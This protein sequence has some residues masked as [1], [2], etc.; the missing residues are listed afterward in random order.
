MTVSSRVVRELG[1]TCRPGWS[2]MAT[3]WP[4]A[5]ILKTI[6]RMNMRLEIGG[7]ASG[8]ETLKPRGNG[9]AGEG[10]DRGPNG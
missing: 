4:L 3:H 6:G 8:L 5:A 1:K 10:L 2:A 7:L 9:G